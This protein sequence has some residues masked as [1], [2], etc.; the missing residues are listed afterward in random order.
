LN[1][2]F[3]KSKLLIIGL[4]ENFKCTVCKNN[5]FKLLSINIIIF[6]HIYLGLIYVFKVIFFSFE[7]VVGTNFLI[8]LLV[9]IQQLILNLY[10]ILFSCFFYFLLIR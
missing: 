3:L 5:S 4:Y 9:Y 2:C 7:L 8:L 1:Q 6:Q 10:V